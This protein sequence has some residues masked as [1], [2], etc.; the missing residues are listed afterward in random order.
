MWNKKHIQINVSP[1]IMNN[2]IKNKNTSWAKKNLIHN[3]APRY[4]LIAPQVQKSPPNYKNPLQVYSLFLWRNAK[5]QSQIIKRRWRRWS[6]QILQIRS[7]STK[8]IKHVHQNLSMSHLNGYDNLQHTSNVEIIWDRRWRNISSSNM[9]N[10]LLSRSITCRR[11]RRRCDIGRLYPR[12]F[13]A[14]SQLSSPLPKK[15]G[16]YGSNY[17]Y[18][19]RC[20]KLN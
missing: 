14:S 13:R 20:R 2:P 19:L 15:G 10:R 6:S 17:V 7:Q 4:N 9:I 1:P 18:K 3:E 16:T 8:L 11:G 5:E 12:A